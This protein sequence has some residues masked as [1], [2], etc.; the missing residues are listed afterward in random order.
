MKSQYQKL[1]DNGRFQSLSGTQT[2]YYQEHFLMVSMIT[3]PRQIKATKMLRL[4]MVQ[5]KSSGMA[6]RSRYEVL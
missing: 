1:D 5:I 6:L 3:L 2:L 4:S